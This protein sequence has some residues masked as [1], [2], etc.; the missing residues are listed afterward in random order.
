[1]ILLTHD[2]LPPLRY[3]NSVTPTLC[4]VNLAINREI[5]NRVNGETKSIPFAC[6]FDRLLCLPINRYIHCSFMCASIFS[7]HIFLILTDGLSVQEIAKKL[8][9][10]ESLEV[11]WSSRNKAF[12]DKKRRGRPKILDTSAKIVLKKARNQ[13]KEET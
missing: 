10:S 13:L 8:E 4:Q 12:E 5:W 1:M 3:V 7:H 2:V 9:K 6:R 11:K